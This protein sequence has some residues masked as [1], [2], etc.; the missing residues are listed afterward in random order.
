M[1]RFRGPDGT[2][3]KVELAVPGSSNVMVV[4]R[5]PDGRSARKDRYNWYISTG[6]EARSVT[7]RLSP[8]RVMQQLDDAT[9]ARLFGRSMPVSR[10]DIEPNLALGIGGGA[11]GLSR[12]IGRVAETPASP[13]R[14][15][16]AM[17]RLMYD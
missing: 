6:P 3:W 10:P 14:G 4:F 2:D 17:R 13:L 7:S 1:R 16:D 8:E 11:A 5:H 9:I 15:D 12:G